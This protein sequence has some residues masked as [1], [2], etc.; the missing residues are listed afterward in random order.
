MLDGYGRKIDYLRLSVTDLCNF[1]CCYCMPEEGVEKRLHTEILSIEE[2][3]EIATA[4]VACGIR[5]IRLTGGEPVV[6]RGMLDICRQIRAV[7]GLEELC[8]T[9]NGSLLTQFA[10]PLRDAGVDRLNISLDTMRPDR[11][12]MMTRLGSLDDV[13]EGIDAAETAGFQELKIDT[14]L[15]SGFNDDGFCDVSGR[16]ELLP[17]PVLCESADAVNRLLCHILSP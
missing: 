15:I 8:L 17:V 12:A 7:P 16:V 3:A 4:A 10:E 11:F 6:R 5:K 2:C 13:L 9:T 1:R 14:V